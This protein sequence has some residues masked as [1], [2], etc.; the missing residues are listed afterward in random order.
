MLLAADQQ[1]EWCKADLALLAAEAK[2]CWFNELSV[3]LEAVIQIP[4]SD[5]VTDLGLNQMLCLAWMKTEVMR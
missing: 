3:L 1:W 4:L 2:L 5:F